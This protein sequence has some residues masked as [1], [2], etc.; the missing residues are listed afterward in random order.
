MFDSLMGF[1]PSKLV[2]ICTILAFV[3]PFIIYQVNQK[4]H[5]HGDPPWMKDR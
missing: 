5:E 2:L 3:I 4:L 1:L